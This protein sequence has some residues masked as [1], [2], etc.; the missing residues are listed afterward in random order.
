MTKEQREEVESILCTVFDEFTDERLKGRYYSM[1]KMSEEEKEDLV[2]PLIVFPKFYF[3]VS[4]VPEINKH[5]L[6]TDDDET[7]LMVGAY[8]D[9]PAVRFFNFYSDNSFL[10][11]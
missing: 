6:Y 7:L 11:L 5:F 2:R 9:W 8:D 3:E 10:L 1:T 4:F